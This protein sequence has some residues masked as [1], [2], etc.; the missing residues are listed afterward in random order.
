MKRLSLILLLAALGCGGAADIAPPDSRKPDP[1][2]TI[3]VRNLLDTTT[4]AGRAHWHIYA[5]LTGPYINQ[6]GIGFQGTNSL[7][8]IRRGDFT[9]CVVVASDSVGQRL[10]SVIA[11]ADTSTSQL[12]PDATAEGT[13][14]AW[15]G[16]DRTLLAGWAA[17]FNP[18]VDAW[19]SAQYL[20]GHG[21]TH[22]DPIKWGLDWTGAGVVTFYERTDT[23][24][25]CARG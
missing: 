11:V 24:P 17:L 10:I 22:D 6:N 14:A 2:L 5:L 8:D 4:A 9:L 3:R 19:L 18:P 20:A 7:A 23:D 15:Y 1:Y 21:L 12:T 13:V 25:M 16:G